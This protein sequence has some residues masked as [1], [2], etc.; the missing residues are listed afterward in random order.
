MISDLLNKHDLYSLRKLHSTFE[1]TIKSKEDTP[2]VTVT[3]WELCCGSFEAELSHTIQ[4][5]KQAGPYSPSA[6]EATAELAFDKVVSSFMGM[7]DEG[8]VK[9]EPVCK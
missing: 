9:I 4:N 6:M 5:E 2:T 8:K 1:F 7:H 3:V